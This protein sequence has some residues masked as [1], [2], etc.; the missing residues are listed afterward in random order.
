M[1]LLLKK[2]MKKI[3]KNKNKFCAIM[4]VLIPASNWTP[5]TRKKKKKQKIL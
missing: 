3:K 1:L 4:H 2:R 5:S